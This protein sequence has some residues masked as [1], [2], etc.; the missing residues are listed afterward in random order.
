VVDARTGVMRDAGVFP[1]DRPSTQLAADLAAFL[2]QCRQNAARPKLRVY[3]AVGAFEDLSANN[4]QAD[5]PAQV[6]GYLTAAYQGSTVTLLE[7]EY[8]ETLLQEVRLD[9][10]GL[11]E[12]GG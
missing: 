10:A 1:A 4:R 12:E 6:R 8:V 3:L 7:R 5:F 11:T 2:R 9:L